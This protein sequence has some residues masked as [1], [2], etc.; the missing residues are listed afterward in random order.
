MI[1][2]WGHRGDKKCAGGVSWAWFSCCFSLSSILGFAGVGYL[3]ESQ[4]S[5]AARR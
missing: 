1:D 5:R 2:D 3:R 4:F